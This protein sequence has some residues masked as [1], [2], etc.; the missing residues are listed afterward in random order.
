MDRRFAL[1][2]SIF[3]GLLLLLVLVIS[4]VA[5]TNPIGFSKNALFQTLSPKTI[6]KVNGELAWAGQN[7]YYNYHE[8]SLKK[9]GESGKILWDKKVTGQ[10]VWMGPEGVFM[11]QDN[12]LIKFD[13]NGSEIFR[14]SNMT[15]KLRVLCVQNNYLLLSGKSL[16]AEYG[17]LL[18][19]SGNIMW[20][21]PFEGN[22]ISGSV[23]PKGVYAALNIINM[24]AKWMLALIGPTGQVL[25]EKTY[26]LPLYQIK[27]VPDGIGVI[28]S[29]KAY[30]MDFYGN[31]IWEHK[32]K[33][34]VLRGD[35]G[36]DG[37][38]AVIVEENAGSLSQDVQNVLVILS[39]QGRHICSYSLDARPNIVINMADYIYIV[40]ENGIMI[41]SQEGLL[42]SKIKQKGIRKL[43]VVDKNYII[44]N[45]GD[46]G[47]LLKNS[48][49]G[50]A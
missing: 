5:N 41:L 49:V 15:D 19:D 8:G 37:S 48:S 42:L 14:K 24:D 40:D 31:V 1:K 10:L 39:G 43:T 32:F 23:D 20:Q 12:I 2:P 11:V 21:V 17:I 27:V 50:G 22:I 38:I 16:D 4:L 7:Y 13:S 6:L 30:V 29:D 28:A 3:C 9:L 44:T 36:N 47:V 25:I 45:Y 35:I 34:R 46:S 18:S 33:G 26:Q